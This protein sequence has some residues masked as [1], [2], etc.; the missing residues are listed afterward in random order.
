MVFFVTWTRSNP[1]P[2]SVT[3]VTKKW[4]FL[5]ASLICVFLQPKT[6]VRIPSLQELTATDGKETKSFGKSRKIS[7]AKEY[8]IFLFKCSTNILCL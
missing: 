2:Q 6:F 1:P 3:F 7:I 5:K 8:D 4:F